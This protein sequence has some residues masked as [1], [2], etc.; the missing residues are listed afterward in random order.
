[1]SK[2]QNTFTPKPDSGTLFPNSFKSTD[3]HPDYTGVYAMPDGTV[4]EVAGWK[5]G[6]YIS[7]RFSDQYDSSQ[8][9]SA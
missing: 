6:D 9:K 5:N 2:R 1:M 4:R 7:L 3:A 8:R